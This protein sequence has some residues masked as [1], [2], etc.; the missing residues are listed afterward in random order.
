M[1]SSVHFQDAT[2]ASLNIPTTRRSIFTGAMS[3][4]YKIMEPLWRALTYFQVWLLIILGFSFPSKLQ[5]ICRLCGK[6]RL[7]L[8]L[9][10]IILVSIS[11][12]FTMDFTSLICGMCSLQSFKCK[13][14]KNSFLSKL[15]YNTFSNLI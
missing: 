14:G 4:L 6:S 8:I 11:I 3:S 15:N 9:L 13:F 10:S 1:P 2:R 12:T 5:F 7:D